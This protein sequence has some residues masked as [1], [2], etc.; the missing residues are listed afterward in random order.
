MPSG[1][2]KS[3]I[4]T[5]L[6]V[7]LN[8]QC[9]LLLS[10]AAMAAYRSRGDVLTGPYI[11][12]RNGPRAGSDKKSPAGQ[13]KTDRHRRPRD[14]HDRGTGTELHGTEPERILLTLINSSLQ[15][16]SPYELRNTAST[17]IFAR[18]THPDSWEFSLSWND[19]GQFGSRRESNPH[20]I[21]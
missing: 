4:M 10:I 21:L 12:A 6:L 16:H 19:N 9:V 14:D 11:K 15:N 13:Q 3:R 2:E 18:A 20:K 5:E 7:I 8:V 17:P 1:D